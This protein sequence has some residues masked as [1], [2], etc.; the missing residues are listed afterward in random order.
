MAEMGK[1]GVDG[2]INNEVYQSARDPEL[3]KIARAKSFRR[4]GFHVPSLASRKWFGTQVSFMREWCVGLVFSRMYQISLELMIFVSITASAFS[5]P[6]HMSFSDL[7]TTGDWIFWVIDVCTTLYFG[8]DFVM[9]VLIFGGW[10]FFRHGQNCFSGIVLAFDVAFFAT[11]SRLRLRSFR[12]F[13]GIIPFLDYRWASDFK[14]I[15]LALTKSWKI[16]LDVFVVLLFCFLVFAVAGLHFFLGSLRRRCSLKDDPFLVSLPGDGQYC[17]ETLAGFPVI[18]CAKCPSNQECTRDHSNPI[19]GYLGFDHF[20]V[21]LLS[22]FII[23]T[24]EGW[25]D[26]FYWIQ[27]AD[28]Q[29]VWVYFVVLIV[30]SSFI[31]LNIFVAVIAE[32]FLEFR[33]EQREKEEARETKEFQRRPSLLGD[34]PEDFCGFK[35]PFKFFSAV[36]HHSAFE[37]VVMSIIALN[38]I[39]M[40]TYYYGMSSNHRLALR[41][42]EYVFVSIFFIEICIRLIGNGGFKHYFRKSFNRFDIFLLIMSIIGILVEEL[43]FFGVMRALRLVRSFGVDSRLRRLVRT[44]QGS[45]MTILVVFVCIIALIIVFGI[46]GKDYYGQRMHELGNP[47][48]TPRLMFDD[49]ASSFLTLFVVMVGD[50]WTTPLFDAMDS[51]SVWVSPLFFIAFY[52]LSV[53]VLMNIF[54]AVILDNFELRDEEKR[55]RQ[56][57]RFEREFRKRPSKFFKHSDKEFFIYS[58]NIFDVGRKAED[59]I[60]SWGAEEIDTYDEAHFGKRVE[61]FEVDEKIDKEE[62]VSTSASAGVAVGIGIND[63]VGV[64]SKK[65]VSNE[66]IGI[67]DVDVKDEEEE[68]VVNVEDGIRVE[69]ETKGDFTDEVGLAIEE[70]GISPLRRGKRGIT[71]STG[72]LKEWDDEKDHPL[73]LTRAKMLR[74]D[75]VLHRGGGS[76]PNLIPDS[77]SSKHMQRAASGDARTRFSH[78]IAAIKINRNLRSLVEYWQT[79]TKSNAPE[80]RILLCLSTKHPVCRWAKKLTSNIIFKRFVFS[81]ILVGCVVIAIE[82]PP[83]KQNTRHSFDNP[84]FVADVTFVSIFF[85][86]FICK[87]LANGLL[88]TP[89]AY[90]RNKFNIVDLLVLVVMLSNIITAFST[91]GGFR[92]FRALRA[93]KPFLVVSRSNEMRVIVQSMVRSIRSVFYVCL[94][95]A[96]FLLLFGIVGVR[97][98]GGLFYFCSD[99][100]VSSK[101]ECIGVFEIDDI[102]VPRVWSNKLTNFDNIF[103]AM[104]SLFQVSMQE[105]W[106]WVM[107]DGMD[108]VG[109]HK[110]PERN[111]SAQNSIYFIAFMMIVAFS[112]YQLF[113]GVFVHEFSRIR[114]TALL[115][116]EQRKWVEMRRYIEH[117]KTLKSV[118]PP[119]TAASSFRHWCFRTVQRKQ[120]EIIVTCVILFNLLVLSTE[121]YGQ[122]QE[123]EYALFYANISC[124]VFFLGEIVIRSSGLGRKQF[125]EDPWNV[126][127][128]VA[129]VGSLLSIIAYLVFENSTVVSFGFIRIFRVV[130]ILRMVDR[131]KRLQRVFGT[132]I[133]SIPTFISV[134]FMFIILLFIYS[135]FGMQMFG[136]IRFQKNVGIRANFRNFPSSAM[137]LFRVTTGE[138]WPWLMNDCELEGPFCNERGGVESDCGS[139]WIARSYFISFVVLASM[140]LLNLLVSLIIENFHRD[141]EGKECSV[142]RYDLVRFR[143]TWKSFDPQGTGR[144]ELFRIPTLLKSVGKP[145]G[146]DQMDFQGKIKCEFLRL[147]LTMR[148]AAYRYAAFHDTLSSLAIM[149]ASP[150]SLPFNDMLHKVHTHNY[151]SMVWAGLK[152]LAVLRAIRTRREL[153]RQGILPFKLEMRG[154]EKLVEIED[155][156]TDKEV[157]AGTEIEMVPYPEREEI[158]SA[159]EA[160]MELRKVRNGVLEPH[161]VPVAFPFLSKNK[162]MLIRLTS[163]LSCELSSPLQSFERGFE[164]D[165]GEMEKDRNVVNEEEKEKVEEE[166]G[167]KCAEDDEGGGGGGESS[168]RWSDDDNDDEEG[169][170]WDR[171][172]DEDGDGGGGGGGRDDHDDGNDDNDDDGT[173]GGGDGGGD[174]HD[175]AD[176]DETEKE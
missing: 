118:V 158:R 170:N 72:S 128:L 10:R 86:E 102:T 84:F 105:A 152:I 22:V 71:G 3:Y 87:I 46:C 90:L 107:Y 65:S 93:L 67:V 57:I 35:R 73:A 30:V 151:I 134:A 17:C 47:G 15:Y 119:P 21:S 142:S 49:I 59:P 23:N 70:V 62:D 139:F 97:I 5:R 114:G 64:H 121:H 68:D 20:G 56:R 82:G 98:F 167:G 2:S 4:F 36:I 162:S 164:F 122:S 41:I 156:M 58:S 40:A 34:I 149:S 137:L 110:Q 74:F 19:N 126:F 157:E 174:D 141:D 168:C 165:I 99:S 136:N 104:G 117:L 154:D 42:V 81:A 124:L 11:G 75:G 31:I 101:E 60:S 63:G 132:L 135:I 50:D 100:S 111:H 112:V 55:K 27:E 106:V 120:F 48:N 150:L 175:H 108:V 51:V 144:I 130:R 7:E 9:R 159:D 125:F 145:L 127:D 76:E 94:I 78:A 33:N 12:F 113:I 25:A 39:A 54:V 16:L 77:E 52:M 146:I 166:E 13:R 6:D 163:I 89:N 153:R 44:I 91:T 29:I 80:Y 37:R 109:E 131:A 26:L 43:S 1:T 32:R 85:F 18:G 92:A 103:S 161:K 79:S 148:H 115:T 138:N 53:N 133:M 88:F 155:V 83:D 123:W 169:R 129:F 160:E 176:T 116:D 69:N 96:F 95:I 24:L 140:L 28:S 61:E 66:I 38:T 8:M 143:D 45:L 172:P 147:E 14:V 173:G 171:V